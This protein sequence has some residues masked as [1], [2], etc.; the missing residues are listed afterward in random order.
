MRLLL[1]IA[2][3]QFRRQWSRWSIV[4]GIGIVAVLAAFSTTIGVRAQVGQ[5]ARYMQ[6]LQQVVQAQVRPTTF[7]MG[8]QV[9]PAL[10]VVRPLNP[11]G[12]VVRGVDAS[13]PAYW[14]FGPG[15]VLPSSPTPLHEAEDI[16]PALDVEFLTRVLLGLLTLAVATHAL[17]MLRP[18]GE[19]V[20]VTSFPVPQWPLWIGQAA[21]SLLVA[22]TAWVVVATAVIGAAT[23]SAPDPMASRAITGAVLR[24]TTPTVAYLAVMVSVG[25]VIAA[26]LS[27]ALS[28]LFAVLLVWL[29]VCNFAPTILLS[30]AR[31]VRPVSSSLAMTTTRDAAVA[32]ELRAGEIDMGNV[33]AN[34]GAHESIVGPPSDVNKYPELESVWIAH[35]REAR[36]QAEAIEGAWRREEEAHD[37]WLDRAEW[38]SPASLF[39]RSAGNA[40]GTGRSARQ[41]WDAAIRAHAEVLRRVLFD[42]RPRVNPRMRGQILVMIRHPVP[43]IRNLPAFD[44]ANTATT[45]AVDARAPVAVLWGYAAA[46]MALS[47]MTFLRVRR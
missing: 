42:D 23:V 45:P 40:A 13:A 1:N 38:L 24:M 43:A 29:V 19:L 5:A 30:V 6:L 15:G 25:S 46:L 32:A 27:G 20:G 31:V 17:G 14:D 39:W 2:G 34:S 8:W 35:V 11:A 10:R 47:T 28:R 7:A 3:H 21:G 44:P 4:A 37:T 18:E 9:E 33:L 26:L 41:A 36:R 16:S 22:L 12:A